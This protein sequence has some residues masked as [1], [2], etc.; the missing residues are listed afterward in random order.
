MKVWSNLLFLAAT[1]SYLKS[2]FVCV[3]VEVWE[4]LVEWII[5]ISYFG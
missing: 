5:V 2:V 3:C 1:F 4:N